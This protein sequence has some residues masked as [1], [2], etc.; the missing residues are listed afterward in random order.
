MGLSDND[1]GSPFYVSSV[2]LPM[3]PVPLGVL[4]IWDSAIIFNSETVH[5]SIG[6]APEK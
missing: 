3:S 4:I 1:S 6:D 5:P 2:G